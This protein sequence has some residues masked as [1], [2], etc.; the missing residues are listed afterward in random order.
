MAFSRDTA[1]DYLKRAHRA[2]R[3]AHAYLITGPAGSGKTALA[4]DLCGLVNSTPPGRDPLA[5]ADVR[6][7]APESKS[8]RILVEQIREIEHALQLKASGPGTKVAI[9]READR[10]QPQAAN[11]FLKTLEEPPAN[12]MLLLLSAQP[13]MLLDT[14]LS[15][16]IMVPLRETADHTV[17]GDERAVLE[18]LRDN[19]RRPKS[20]FSDAFALARDFHEQL[21]AIKGRISKSV[22]EEM[23]AES[24]RYKQT[25][26]GRWLAGREDYFE[27]LAASEYAGVRQRLMETLVGWWA[28]VL[29]QRQ[30]MARLDYPDFAEAT[31]VLSRAITDKTAMEAIDRLEEL[32]D[33]LGRNVQEALAIEAAFLQ[34][35]QRGN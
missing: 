34:V 6:I 26:D 3:L 9:I 1:L 32:R 28:D 22:D 4:S 18:L 8:R 31:E 25:T 15:R 5:G 14:I 24:A 27:A 11:A 20:G 30:G 12:S 10:M 13:Q 2:G 17:T 29:R 35:F 33:Q 23:K 16:C 7:A 21:A 19:A